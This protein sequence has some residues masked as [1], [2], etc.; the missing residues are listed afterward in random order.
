MCQIKHLD[1]MIVKPSSL[2]RAWQ[3]RNRLGRM[4]KRRFNY[5]KHMM[6]SQKL[7]NETIPVNSSPLN[8]GDL[9]RVRSKEEIMKTLDA[10]N[11]L[12]GCVFTEEMWLYCG[13]TQRVFRR[14]NKFLDER[15]YLIKK[16]KNTVLLEGL[17]CSGTKDFGECDKSCFFFWKESWLEKLN[18]K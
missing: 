16:C 17:F 13:T 4:V 6:S 10:W 1:N 2:N 5:L 15:D 7:N 11:S 3:F 9:L 12:E 14:L 18:D 8:A